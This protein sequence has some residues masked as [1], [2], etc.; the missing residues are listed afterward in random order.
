M[1]AADVNLPV[2]AKGGRY[3][4]LDLG[5]GRDSV[6]LRAAHVGQ[7]PSRS[8]ASRRIRAQVPHRDVLLVALTGW[9]QAAD[10]ERSRQAGLDQHLVKPI[11]P[12]HLESLLASL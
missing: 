12:E 6:T 10:R 3:V 4:G 8:A 2:G 9:G 1:G 7:P 11:D 5:N